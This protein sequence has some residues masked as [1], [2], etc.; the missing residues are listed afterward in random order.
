MKQST[1]FRVQ[2]MLPR[3]EPSARYPGQ[4]AR[5][6]CALRRRGP[7]RRARHDRRILAFTKRR[8]V[9]GLHKTKIWLTFCAWIVARQAGP[10]GTAFEIAAAQEG[11]FTTKQAAEARYS[12]QLLTHYVH[13]GRAIRVGR[14]IYRLVHFPTGEHEELVAAWLWSELAGVVSHQSALTLHGLSDALPSHIHLT[15]PGRVAPAQVACPLRCRPPPR[16][17][18]SRRSHLVRRR[19]HDKPATLAQ[20]LRER[21]SLAGPRPTGGMQAIHR[22]LVTK[23]ELVDVKAA[24]A[25]FGGLAA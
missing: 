15:L 5:S 12:P 16:R 13:A 1:R 23:R 8:C 7:L 25:P 6:G 18:A 9:I 20:R 21:R 10:T 3:K 24:L 2:A 14:S 22:G 4:T 17:R 11:L 19:P